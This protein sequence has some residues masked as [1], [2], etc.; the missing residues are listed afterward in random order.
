MYD[1]PVFDYQVFYKL[2]VQLYRNDILTIILG[3]Y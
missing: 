2:Y 3:D 1:Y